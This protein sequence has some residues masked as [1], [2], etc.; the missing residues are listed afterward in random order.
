MCVACR[1]RFP[2]K[3]LTRYVCPDTTAELET[4]GPVSDPGMKKPGRGYYVCVQARCRDRFPKMI[5]GLMKKRKGKLN[6]GKGSGRRP[7]C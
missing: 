3:E 4:D 7:G 5:V 2:K 1:Q 6:D